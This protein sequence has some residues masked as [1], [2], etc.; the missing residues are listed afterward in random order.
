[1]PMRNERSAPRFD[2]TKPR[3]L[4]RY[5]KDLEDH[6]Q[7]CAVIDLANQKWW[8]LHYVSVE[9]ADLWESLTDWTAAT[10]WDLVKDAVKKRY[11]A[12]Q[13]TRRHTHHELLTLIR[14]RAHKDFSSVTEWR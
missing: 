10:T 3:E 9:I 8:A 1:M 11:P 5:F 7:R 6:F 4:V 14:D 12:S 13:T 2:P